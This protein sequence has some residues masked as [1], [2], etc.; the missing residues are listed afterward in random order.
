MDDSRQNG[1][2]YA[3]RIK[4]GSV[5]FV[6]SMIVPGLGQ[7]YN[8]QTLTGI[9]LAVALISFMF[10]AGLLGLLHTFGTAVAYTIALWTFQLAVAI[11]AAVVAVRQVEHNKL[12]TRTWRSYAVAVGVIVAIAL[13]GLTFLDGILGVRAYVV[14]GQSMS[15]TLIG[16]DRCIADTKYYKTHSPKRGDVIVFKTPN[17]MLLTKRVVAVGGDTIEGGPGGT[18]VD[19]Q[20]LS[21]PYMV[22]D[23]DDTSSNFGPVKVP[24]NE[25]FVMGDNRSGSNDSRQFGSVGENRVIGKVLYVYYSSGR[26]GRIGH[27][28]Q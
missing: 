19:G 12:P 10:F 17:G 14:S 15:P 21:E 11:H 23:P 16:G 25:L 22:Q 4:R 8:G 13:V 5:A 7:I 24:S 3:S 18:L 26:E 6:L 9:L 28:I 20:Q 27:A 1:E 2:R